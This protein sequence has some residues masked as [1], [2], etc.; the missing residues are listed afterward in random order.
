MC[1][2]RALE[3]GEGGD[4]PA[5]LLGLRVVDLEQEGLVA[6]DDQRAVGH[7]AQ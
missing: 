7:A 5:G 4:G 6:L 1:S 2:G 3:L